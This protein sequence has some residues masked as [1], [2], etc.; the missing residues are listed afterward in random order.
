MVTDGAE[1]ARPLPFGDFRDRLAEQIEVE[2]AGYG[3]ED[4]LADDLELDSV[5]RL[6]ALVAVEELGVHLP[7]D[8][9]GPEQ[10][11][12]GLHDLYLRALED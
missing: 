5:Q 8:S 10:T 3:T 12:G 2:L 6:E 11:L 9:V 1:R 7:D 4:R